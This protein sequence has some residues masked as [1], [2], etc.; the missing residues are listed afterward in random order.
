[1]A[2]RGFTGWVGT[3]LGSSDPV[4]LGRFYSELF[5]WE[6][7]VADVLEGGADAYVDNV[8]RWARSIAYPGS[9]R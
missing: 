5:G 3:V 8:P 4:A 2:I 1:M 9:A 6:M 7:T